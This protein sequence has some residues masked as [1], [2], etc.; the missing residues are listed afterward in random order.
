MSETPIKFKA[1]PARWQLTAQAPGGEADSQGLLGR[2]LAQRVGQSEVADFLEPRLARLGDPMSLPSM[3]DAVL[4]IFQ[5]IDQGQRVAI[6]GDYDVDG[7]SSV[8]LLWTVLSALGLRAELFVP[9][10]M[11]EGYGLSRAGLD[12]LFLQ[13]GKPDLLLVLDCGT[14]SLA[15][16]SWLREQGVDCVIIDHHEISPQG[17]PEAVALVN[18]RLGAGYHYLCTVGLVFKVAHALLKLRPLPGFD[19]KS[20][21]DLVALGTVADLVPLRDEN[22]IL[23]KRGLEVLAQSR[24]P[25][26]RALM[27][28]A[29]VKPESMQAGQ[30]SFRLGPR[31]NASGRLEQAMTSL[32]LLLTGDSGRA[33]SLAAE[34]EACNRERQSVEA[35]V[36]EEAL[37]MLQANPQWG[38]QP[39]LVLGSTSWHQGVIG[40]VA[41]RLVRLT[42]RPTVLFA[43][44]ANGQGKGSGRSV[45]GFSLVEAIAAC[46]DHLLGGGGHAM[47]AGFSL[48]EDQLEGFR[49]ALVGHAGRVLGDEA[50]APVLKLD[51]QAKLSDLTPAFL[52][53]YRQLEPFGMG[54]PEPLFWLRAVEPLLPGRVLNEKHLLFKLRQGGAQMDACWFSAPL[55]ELP[56]PPWDVAVKLS[57]KVWRGRRS[58]SAIVEAARSSS[59][60][61]ERQ[62]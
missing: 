12:R 45:E 5:A 34:L 19:L 2:L 16:V 17:L 43:F 22:R 14:T 7:V 21:L 28:I 6:Y 38:A 48:R 25:G 15:E 30:I 24:R 47:A 42:H 11:D 20:C 26:L 1:R 54:N 29:G 39:A 53:S 62:D 59:E 41:S 55:D 23:V 10:R 33:Q 46:R 56:P 4:R 40:I 49:A 61:D 51:A 32:Q 60:C 52:D 3:A 58:W 27:D 9:S 31:L 50:P 37:A 57:H 44:D 13:T 8:A 36:Y 35:G 18:P